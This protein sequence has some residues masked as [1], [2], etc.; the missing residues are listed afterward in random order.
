MT[1]RSGPPDHPMAEPPTIPGTPTKPQSV[2]P[3]GHVGRTNAV[4]GERRARR[5][6]TLRRRT[7]TVTAIVAVLTG[8]S[9]TAAISKESSSPRTGKSHGQHGALGC[10]TRRARPEQADWE[11]IKAAAQMRRIGLAHHRTAH[12]RAFA[13]YLGLSEL[14]TIQPLAPGPCRDALTYLYGNLLDLQDAYPGENWAPLRRL[15]AR[16]PSIRA[17]APRRAKQHKT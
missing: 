16:E 14:A 6:V 1:P 10:A 12:F 13:G 9:A 2:R 11:N 15:V 3:A 7:L 17:C 5:T 8:S 4:S